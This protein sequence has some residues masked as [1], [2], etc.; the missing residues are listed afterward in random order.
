MIV[1]VTLVFCNI[2]CL[3]I[4]TISRLR[5]PSNSNTNFYYSIATLGDGMS[6]GSLN[7]SLSLTDIKTGPTTLRQE[8]NSSITQTARSLSTLPASSEEE[9]Y[10]L[11][12]Q[13]SQ[14]ESTGDERLD[15]GL[16]DYDSDGHDTNTDLMAA[17]QSDNS[18]H[19]LTAMDTG[20]GRDGEEGGA[21]MEAVPAETVIDPMY[22]QCRSARV[23][24]QKDTLVSVSVD[25]SFGKRVIVNSPSI[26]SL[27]DHGQIDKTFHGSRVMRGN[28][29]VNE[30]LSSSFDPA[31]LVC[32]SCEN[33][34][35]ILDKKPVMFLFSDQNFMATVPGPNKD[36]LNVVRV[37]NASLLELVEVARKILG[38]APL[39]AGNI[40]MFG[41]ASYLSRM[42][43]SA[44]ARDW[45]EVVALCIASWHGVRVCSLIPLIVSDCPGTIV[46]ELSELS[47]WLDMV[48]DGNPQGLQE[49]WRGLIAAMDSC[50]SGSVV[51]DV[52]ESY[53]IL[54]P[55]SLE[56]RMLTKPVTFALPTHV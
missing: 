52:M 27:E 18:L 4:T 33:D 13:H 38:N 37:E 31:K 35:Q 25:E 54:L 14:D 19:Q 12:G 42:G 24:C 56:S 2:I 7:R 46:R 41:S 39:T 40:L 11:L 48:Y 17:E 8:V 23:S 28:A 6:G 34:H 3:V 10:A 20:V 26:G 45:T 16:L 49:V 43:T 50:S 51:L 15:T 1:H 44:Y 9:G 30:S 36:C 21:H 55:C 29:T 22:Y 32:I 47:I 53:K 5:I